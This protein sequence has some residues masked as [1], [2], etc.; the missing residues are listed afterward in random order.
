MNRFSKE[1]DLI[2]KLITIITSL[3]ALIGMLKNQSKNDKIFKY[4]H[5]TNYTQDV[6]NK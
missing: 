3:I 6:E 5:G 2:I 4:Y 1:L